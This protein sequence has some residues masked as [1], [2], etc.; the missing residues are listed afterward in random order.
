VD[1]FFLKHGVEKR[2]LRG[3]LIATFKIF[4]AKEKIDTV[5]MKVITMRIV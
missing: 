2:R 3:D 1:V 5:N 4:T